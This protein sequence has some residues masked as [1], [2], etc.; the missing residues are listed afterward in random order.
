[1]N[2]AVIVNTEEQSYE[3]QRRMIK[4]G[5]IWLGAGTCLLDI[6]RIGEYCWHRDT[7]IC[8]TMTTPRYQFKSKKIEYGYVKHMMLWRPI[9]DAFNVRE[10]PGKFTGIKKHAYDDAIK[11]FNGYKEELSL[12]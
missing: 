2:I 1:M 11:I 3:I 9:R 6:K 10:W 4:R 12:R 7:G 5:G 8:I